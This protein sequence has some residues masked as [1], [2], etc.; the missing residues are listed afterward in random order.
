MTTLNNSNR[1]FYCGLCLEKRRALVL[2]GIGLGKLVGV[3]EAVEVTHC[4]SG[5]IIINRAM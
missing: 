1:T 4:F 2:A 5:I 3:D